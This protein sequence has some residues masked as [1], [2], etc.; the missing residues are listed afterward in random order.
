LAEK[1]H[2]S[3]IDGRPERLFFLPVGE[4]AANAQESV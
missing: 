2:A 3:P 1:L 4:L